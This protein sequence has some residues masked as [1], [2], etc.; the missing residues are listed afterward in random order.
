MKDQD[1]TENW[2]LEE[3][4]EVD[5]RWVL[6]PSEQKLTEQWDLQDEP[7]ERVGEWQPVDYQKPSRRGASWILPTVVTVALLAVLGYSAV[8][9]LPRLVNT[10]TGQGS[11]EG[12]A[13]VEPSDATPPAVAGVAG[14]ESTPTATPTEEVSPT[15]TEAPPTQEAPPAVPADVVQQ[16]F[17]TVTSTY[18]VNARSAPD[19]NA[20]VVRVVLQGETM[21]VF[22]EDG[23]FLRLFLTDGPL[24]E[25]QAISGTIAYAAKEYFAV[26]EQPV[27]RALWEAVFLGAGLPVP[28]SE[29]PTP[30]AE[31]PSTAITDTVTATDTVT[32]TVAADAL[33]LPT[34][35]PAPGQTGGAPAPV[36][37]S[38]TISAVNGLNVR[39]NPEIAADIVSLLENGA[40]VDVIGRFVDSNWYK[41]R[42]PDGSEGWV[43][44]DFVTLNGDPSALP[45]TR[46]ENLPLPTPAPTITPTLE[47]GD[48]TPAPPPAPYVA[49]LP[50]GVTGVTVPTANGVNVRTEPNTDADVIDTVPL[51][52][53][54]PAVGRSE[55]AL[56]IMVELPDGSRGW[57]FRAAI[58]PNA[59]LDDLPVSEGETLVAPAA[60]PEPDAATPEAETPEVETPEAETPEGTPEAESTPTAP[61]GGASATV[62]SIV[63]PIYEDA[64]T[65]AER[66]E[67]VPRGT[68][69]AVTGRNEDGSWVQVLSR[70][71]DVGWAP[72]GSISV[73]VDITT[74]PVAP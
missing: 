41:V 19:E 26:A 22:G 8:T 35:T 40:T 34:P 33:L 6:E 25:G 56:W 57:L 61:A 60:T 53:A 11:T 2:R 67:V 31:E 32:D 17:G 45:V 43:A 3:G 64:S 55:D 62:T 14:A 16:L 70:G 44:A 68:T 30:V 63:A 51:N 59:V 5:D 7:P 72:A 29:E 42:L 36:A 37:V 52:A 18:G 69:L 71:G 1:S 21:F 15:P 47:A 54:L 27:R 48:A 73:N 13:T 74:L 23:D 12:T 46:L 4:G 65:E 66:L 9:L 10:F 20:E 49:E 28:G 50:E 58:I 24:Q 38:L 39:T